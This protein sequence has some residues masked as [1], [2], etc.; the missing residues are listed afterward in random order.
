MI[1]LDL[2]LHPSE[3]ITKELPDWI[4]DT[5]ISKIRQQA[6]QHARRCHSLRGFH[7]EHANDYDLCLTKFSKSL[8]IMHI[9]D[10]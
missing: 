3:V 2:N 7:G 4:C 10:M 9:C 1:C 5:T 6:R 8:K